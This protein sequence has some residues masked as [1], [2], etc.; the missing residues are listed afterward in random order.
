MHDIGECIKADFTETYVGMAIL[1]SAAY[2]FTVVNVKDS[3]LLFAY[4]L[5]KVVDDSVKIVN[6]II[7]TVMCMA[8]IKADTQLFVVDNTIVDACKFLKDRPISVPFPAIVSKAILQFVS[9]LRT[10]FNPFT[11]CAIPASTP[12]PTCA[13]GWRIKV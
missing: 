2:I 5:V 7:A 6:D 4:E 1:G 9:L 3:N 11:I 12:A 13:P 10:V 8:G